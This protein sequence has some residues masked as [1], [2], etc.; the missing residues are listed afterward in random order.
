MSAIQNENTNLNTKGDERMYKNL[1]EEMVK[2]NITQKQISE[3]LNVRAATVS[4]KINGKFPFK[5]NEAFKIQT[6]FFP[7]LS[8]EYLFDTK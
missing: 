8:I 1:E 7:A 2:N 6:K 3:L 5:L 4:D